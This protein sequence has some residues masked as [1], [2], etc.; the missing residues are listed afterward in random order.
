MKPAKIRDGEADDVI[1]FSLGQCSLGSILVAASANG[2]CAVLLGD[3]AVV[4]VED[5]QNRFQHATLIPA[6]RAFDHVAGRVIARVDQRAGRELTA[7]PDFA[8]DVRGTAFQRR[9]W[10]CLQDIPVGTTVTYAQVARSIGQP[11]AVR[12]VAN[13]CGANAVA[14]L[15]PCHRVQRGDGKLSGYRWGIERKRA[16]LQREGV[17]C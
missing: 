10:S 3:D 4:L 11:Q 12:A 1:R 9:V 5:L 17:K 2:V 8:I 6:D 14:V 7:K 16:L 13:A 15:V